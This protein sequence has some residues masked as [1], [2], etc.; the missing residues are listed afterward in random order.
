MVGLHK[1]TKIH[2]LHLL[3]L[4]NGGPGKVKSGMWLALHVVW[5]VLVRAPLRRESGEPETWE[6]RAL[7]ER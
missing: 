6:E 3:S 1:D 2:F 5:T 4:F 7:R